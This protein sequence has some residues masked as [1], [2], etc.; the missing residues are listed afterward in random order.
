MNILIISGLRLHNNLAC[1]K[2][3]YLSNTG[4]MRIAKAYFSYVYP[5]M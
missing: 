1:M 4:T 5:A 3:T 2:G